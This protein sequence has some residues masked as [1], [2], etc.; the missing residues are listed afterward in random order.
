MLFDAGDVEAL[1]REARVHSE[2][3]LGHLT[4]D[5]FQ[6]HARDVE[7]LSPR[8]RTYIGIGQTVAGSLEGTTLYRIHLSSKKLSALFYPDF[9]TSAL[10]RLSE[11]TKINLLNG[12][13]TVF[14]HQSDGRV[15]ALME[16]SHY[17]T[18]DEERYDDQLAFELALHNHFG[19]KLALIPFARVASGMIRAGLALPY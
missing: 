16:K 9:E 1:T 10:P 18:G 6:V 8:L 13:V 4:G 19:D 15:S 5:K 17:M 12:D 2:A 3:G 7:R 11:R 14:D